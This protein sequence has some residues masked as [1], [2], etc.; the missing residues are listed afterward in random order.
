MKLAIFSSARSDFGILKNLIIRLKKDKR[1]N[2]YL[3]IG[4]AHTSKIFGNTIKE[5]K[6]IDIKKIFL[7]LKYSKSK[8]YNILKSA[9]LTLKKSNEILKKFKFDGAI[10]LGDRYE[11][12]LFSF[13]CLFYKIPIIHLSGGSNTK[14]SIDDVFR[15]SI[16]KM[17]KIHLL[18]TNFHKTN[19][20]KI[21]IE[22]NLFI[23]GAP[24]LEKIKY[25]SKKINF[26]VKEKKFLDEKKEKKIIACFHPETTKSL[27]E[28]LSNLKSL[29]D[30]LN[31]KR[32]KIIFT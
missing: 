17:A 16:S 24:G 32:H 12:M 13:C 19:L 23:V 31:S 3:I 26:S 9:E 11:M 14:G 1:F 2:P 18:E 22:K 10:I 5:I 21:G 28:N 20:L 6:T 7:G 30:F 4:G 29:I 15:Y 8:E 25:S 27:K